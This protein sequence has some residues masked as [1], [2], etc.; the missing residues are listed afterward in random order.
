MENVIFFAILFFTIGCGIGFYIRLFIARMKK[1]VR[2]ITAF[3]QESLI[4]I[5]L[6]W[7]AIFKYKTGTGSIEYINA[8]SRFNTKQWI[9]EKMKNKYRFIRIRH[10]EL[11]DVWGSYRYVYTIECWEPI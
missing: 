8:E 9:R 4:E 5:L 3:L 7:T 10:K 6:Y 1:L 2:P 11:K